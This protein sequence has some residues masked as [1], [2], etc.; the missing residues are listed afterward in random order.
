MS[1]AR[2]RS[3][4]PRRRRIARPISIDR[5]LP[6]EGNDLRPSVAAKNTAEDGNTG[7]VGEGY[8]FGEGSLA[9]Q[10][11][12]IGQ[13]TAMTDGAVLRIDGVARQSPY[14]FPRG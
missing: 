1:P 12:R 10:A 9:G 6:T 5:R 7:I 13:A 4:S 11:L 8:F 2:P 3:D 14:G